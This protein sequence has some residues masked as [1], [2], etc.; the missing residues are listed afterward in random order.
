MGL[1]R[2]SRRRLRSRDQ[3]HLEVEVGAKHS[4]RIQDFEA[5]QVVVAIEICVDPV[6]KRLG[7]SGLCAGN[8]QP[9][10]LLHALKQVVV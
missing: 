9:A 8:A 2:P 3:R 1:L 6:S 5:H 4:P 7:A 10:A